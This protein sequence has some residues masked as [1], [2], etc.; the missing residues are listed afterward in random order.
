MKQNLNIQNK[1]IQTKSKSYYKPLERPST[2]FMISQIFY[3]DQYYCFDDKKIYISKFM[4]KKFV[5]KKARSS[6]L[7]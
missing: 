4:R 6:N 5:K 3:K 7:F 2:H 1:N